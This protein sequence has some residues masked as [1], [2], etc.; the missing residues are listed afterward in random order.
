MS[1]EDARILFHD[2]LRLGATVTYRGHEGNA[3]IF[4]LSVAPSQAQV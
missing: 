2:L 1:S 3:H 4:A